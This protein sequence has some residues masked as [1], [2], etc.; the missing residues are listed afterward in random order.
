M[1]PLPTAPCRWSIKDMRGYI[2]PM[3][4]IRC[5]GKIYNGILQEIF[6]NKQQIDK[7]NKKKWH[8]GIV[9]SE[10]IILKKEDYARYT[11]I[12]KI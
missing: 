6:S 2:V 9:M 11:R 4:N 8:S 10:L 7:N 12:K 1:F 3:I 5:G